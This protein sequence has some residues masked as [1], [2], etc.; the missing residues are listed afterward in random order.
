MPAIRTPA[1]NVDYNNLVNDPMGRR[2]EARRSQRILERTRRVVEPPAPAPVPPPAP[3]APPVAPPPQPLRRSRR[4]QGLPPP[5]P[6]VPEPPR[7][8]PRGPAVHVRRRRT[9]DI[10]IPPPRR[11]P[12]QQRS[13]SPLPYQ[14]PPQ[15]RNYRPVGEPYT[16]TPGYVSYP[17][18]TQYNIRSARP[19]WYSLLRD[20]RLD[21]KAQRIWHR[22]TQTEV[23]SEMTN[24]YNN[25]WMYPIAPDGETSQPTVDNR[26]RWNML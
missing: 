10:H 19:I 4:L 1:R 5:L 24:I 18:R 26:H 25:R 21:A 9:P 11:Q 3:P 20:E 16:P 15:V 17:S 12:R 23:G 2:P 22:R 14:C 7:H 8:L 6:P 13:R